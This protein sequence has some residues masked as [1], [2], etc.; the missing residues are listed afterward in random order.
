MVLNECDDGLR[1]KCALEVIS[2]LARQLPSDLGVVF[3]S[4]SSLLGG[5]EEGG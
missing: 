4:F 1:F 3:W 2:K 5:K